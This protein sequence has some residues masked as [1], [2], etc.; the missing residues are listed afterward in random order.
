[1]F[2]LISVGGFMQQ[3]YVH[4]AYMAYKISLLAEKYFNCEVKPFRI[5]KWEVY[6]CTCN[7][8]SLLSH[9]YPVY[10]R[11]HLG[12]CEGGGSGQGALCGLWWSPPGTRNYPAL[13]Q[14]LL[15]LSTALFIALHRNGFHT[16]VMILWSIS[17]GLSAD[18]KNS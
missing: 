17:T 6:N 1:M 14:V 3:L 7:F 8:N 11:S 9:I 15:S 4:E 10:V 5:K 13:M 2:A 16:S 18:L 12:C